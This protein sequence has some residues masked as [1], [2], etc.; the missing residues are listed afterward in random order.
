MGFIPSFQF[1]NISYCWPLAQINPAFNPIVRLGILTYQHF[2]LLIQRETTAFLSAFVVFPLR[3]LL[4]VHTNTSHTAALPPLLA[5]RRRRR[6]P[7][8][9]SRPP[10]LPGTALPIARPAP[11]LG[12]AADPPPPRRH[13]CHIFET[14]GAVAVAPP[15]PGRVFVPFIV[16]SGAVR[17]GPSSPGSCAE[18]ALT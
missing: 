11:R 15:D 2:F 7:P 8:A 3:P 17:A 5:R 12:R 14:T 13:F 16:G 1:F 6:F 4:S 9:P 18:A 10:A